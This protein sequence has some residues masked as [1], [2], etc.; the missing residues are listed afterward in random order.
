VDR[1]ALAVNHDGP[2]IDHLVFA[3]SDLATA[4]RA[5]ADQLGVTPTPGGAHVGL[6]TRNELVHLGNG[7][8]LEIL[9]PDLDQPQPTGARPFGVDR[10][11][12][13]ALVAWCARPSGPLD[14][15]VG[16]A[17]VEGVDMGQPFSMS[18][19]RPDG[20]LLQWRVTPPQLDGPFGC[21]LPFVIDWQHSPHP[22]ES[23]PPGPELIELR[24][25]TPQPDELRA[26]VGIIG[27]MPNVT[28]AAGD[29]PALHARIRTAAGEVTLSS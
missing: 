28:I 2:V 18:R 7:T 23:L 19:Q 6:G 21:A 15:I 3:C 20:V 24:V 1:A 29:A 8:Y 16:A 25:V 13:P 9:G 5:I 26:V 22:T 27:T 4:T 11:A 17:Q 14:E 12:R 10:H